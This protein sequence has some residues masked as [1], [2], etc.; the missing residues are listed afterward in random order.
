M[1]RSVEHHSSGV[2]E[3][4]L[5]LP[6]SPPRPLGLVSNTAFWWSLG[7]SLLLPVAVVCVVLPNGVLW[8]S[9]LAIVVGAVIGGALLGLAAAPGARE[10]VPAMVLLRG[11]LG[12]RVSC[13]PTVAN[14]AQ[15][16]G[17]ARF[18]I[19][20]IAEAAARIVG[21]PRWSFGILAGGFIAF[22]LTLLM[23]LAGPGTGWTAWWFGGQE[24][25]GIDP[26]KGLSVS[27]VSLG[28][29]MVLTGVIGLPAVVRNRKVNGLQ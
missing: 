17:W 4:A 25:L 28:V 10:G 1:D 8:V 18:E 12:G 2:L 24:D 22:Q 14:L 6:D 27:L 9:V 16:V 13:V 23:F 15:C 7:I 5:T 29:A 21:V 26:A 19:V 3:A 20:V 11:L